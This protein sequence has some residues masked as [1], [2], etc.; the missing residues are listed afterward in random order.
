MAGSSGIIRRGAKDQDTVSL[1]SGGRH[2]QVDQ[3]SC[4]LANERKKEVSQ[5]R[6]PDCIYHLRC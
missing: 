5:H 2:G 1:G 6:M 3:A 4:G